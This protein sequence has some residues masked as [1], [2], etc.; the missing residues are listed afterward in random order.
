MATQVTVLGAGPGGEVAGVG[1]RPGA[2][3]LL[4]GGRDGTVRAWYLHWE[5]EERE[6]SEGETFHG[7]GNMLG[8]RETTSGIGCGADGLHPG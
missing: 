4:S 3:L 6:E 5:L 8:S 7:D 1:I 2:S